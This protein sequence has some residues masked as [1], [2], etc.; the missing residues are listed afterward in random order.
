MRVFLKALG[1][2]LNEAELETWSRDFHQAG[3][4]I[5]TDSDKA[6]LVVINT[7][8]VTS[9]AVRKSR[10]LMHRI[11]RQNPEAKL[12]VSGCY[13][14]LD[15][16]ANRAIEGVDLV[17]DNQ[18]KDRLVDIVKDK[19][20]L[21]V[22]PD[23]A[24]EST[25]HHLYERGRQ[26]A[27]VKVQDGCRYQCTFCIVTKARGDEKS[28]SINDIVAEIQ[29][30]SSEGVQEIVLTGVHLGGYGSDIQSNLTQLI[31]QALAQT[32]IPR[33]RMG[34]L[35][36]WDLPEQFWSLFQNTRLM[37]H[38]HLPLQ[39]G[40]DSVL[41]RMARRCKSSE[42]KRLVE[43]ARSQV[44]D[45]NLSTDVIVGFPGETEDE[46]QDS[47]NFIQECG[48]G[49]MH[50]FA[51][52]QREGTRA[53][54][55][56]NPVKRET[57]RQ[58]SQDLHKLGETL[59]LAAFSPYQNRVFPVLLEKIRL[60]KTTSEQHLMGY[61]PNFIRVKI[62]CTAEDQHLE[63]SIKQVKLE[64]LSEKGDFYTGSIQISG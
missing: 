51:Y 4:Q 60:D 58:R 47:V 8:A 55:M 63:N 14:S 5:V 6:N 7:C 26:R 16:T 54:I 21:H 20:N 49:H 33:I 23:S 27:F 9:E 24:I 62:A 46:W 45:F 30:L 15:P 42:F 61:T 39:S 52:S 25:V 64:E 35:E 10:K 48:F 13:A 28:R 22:M 32:E 17:V 36:P 3:H 37:P 56:P 29:Q 57:I 40:S 59:K 1:C 2:R 31:E 50:I 12:V 53:A 41:K 34:A 38:L 43:Q 44:K 19:L 11:H 18:Q